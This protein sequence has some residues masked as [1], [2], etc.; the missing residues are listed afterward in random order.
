MICLNLGDGMLFEINSPDHYPV[1]L[2]D[3]LINSNPAF[4]FGQFKDLEIRMQGLQD[5]DPTVDDSFAQP[6]YFGFSFTE[7]GNY[8]F[9]DAADSDQQS[10][11]AVMAENE[12]CLDPENYIM[13]R[14]P[15]ALERLGIG[16]RGNIYL[17]A[18][19]LMIGVIFGAFV[20]TLI[21]IIGACKNFTSQPWSV[22]ATSKGGY[23]QR[24]REYAGYEALELRREFYE[25]M[26]GV[27]QERQ[28]AE[29]AMAE[30]ENVLW[31]Q[32]E[33]EME[34][35]NMDVLPDLERKVRRVMRKMEK[36]QDKKQRR[37]EE[38]VEQLAGLEERLAE[39]R[40]MNER[41][42]SE[43]MARKD[44]VALLALDKPALERKQ[45][46]E[47]LSRLKREQ[48]QREEQQRREVQEMVTGLK[49]K[50]EDLSH[51]ISEHSGLDELQRNKLLLELEQQ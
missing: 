2:K 29:T 40:L 39:L 11:I 46:N 38:L 25:E 3:S 12:R 50:R 47:E 21:L 27:W 15:N 18:D 42:I 30:T 36:A 22:K 17:E 35:V 34:E 8:V 37:R 19:Y 23:R 41:L 32:E 7:A 9:A 6:Y 44:G 16:F 33:S 24:Q 45:D 31:Q 48:E 51:A 28:R 14:E 1:Y 49:K 26:A 5:P 43:E 13:P 4:D 10:L 20:F